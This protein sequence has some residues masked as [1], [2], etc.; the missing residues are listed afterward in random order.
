MKVPASLPHPDAQFVTAALGWLELGLPS[1]AA[2]ELRR[3]AAAYQTNPEVLEVRWQICAAAQDWETALAVAETLV[4]RAPERDSGWVH[5]AYSLRRVKSGGLQAA[6]DALQP[7]SE[8]FPTNAIIPY[9]LACY[10]AQFGR[11]DEALAWLRKA[12]RVAEDAV[13]IKTMALADDDL[14]PVWDRIRQ[15]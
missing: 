5:R 1:E 9:N 7:A 11:L 4:E 14:R 10:A 6:W 15:M 2:M 12:M 13:S 3:I 8:L